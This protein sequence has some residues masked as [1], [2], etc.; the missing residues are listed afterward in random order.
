MTELTIK[1]D[2]PDA[3]RS[4]LRSA[5]DNKVRALRD[6]IRRTQANLSSLEQKYGFTTAE[7]LNREQ[8]GTLDDDNLEFIE[9]L[10]EH[11]IRGRLQ[12]E[13]EVLEEIHIYR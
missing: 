4:E 3:V 6:S 11:R 7:L 8:Q 13:L 10:G 2:R 5:I 12:D 9:W 1:S